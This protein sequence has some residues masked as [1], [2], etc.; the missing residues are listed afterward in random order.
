MA[1][2]HFMVLSAAQPGQE[3]AFEAWYD[4]QHIVDLVKVPGVISA[5]RFHISSQSGQPEVPKWTCV[6]I[7]ELECDDPE[8]VIARIISLSGSDAMPSTE[9]L[10]KPSVIRII[11]Q[12]SRTVH[13]AG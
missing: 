13:A 12:H 3:A 1:R 5:Q 9:T 6:A 2:H 10:D 4:Q 7:Y 8:E 11:A